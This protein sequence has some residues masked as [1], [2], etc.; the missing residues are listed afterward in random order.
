MTDSSPA[1]DKVD[2]DLVRALVAKY[3]AAAPARPSLAELVAVAAADLERSG[4]RVAFQVPEGKGAPCGR[5]FED[6][7]MLANPS[8]FGLASPPTAACATC[9]S[10]SSLD[11]GLVM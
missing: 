4:V 3:G 2:A 7:F 8:L 5:S 1:L 10:S 9:A 11:H 6:A